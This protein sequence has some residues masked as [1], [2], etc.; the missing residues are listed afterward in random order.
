[1]NECE[2][3]WLSE[4]NMKKTTFPLFLFLA[5]VFPACNEAPQTTE[6]NQKLIHELNERSIARGNK[7]IA[8]VGATLV[9]G[10]GGNPVENATVIIENNTIHFAGKTGDQEIPDGAD[11]ID[12]EGQ[13]I[14]PGFIDAHYHNDYSKLMAPL[15]LHNGVTSVR[16]P[17]AWVDI[18]DSVRMTGKPIPR[19]FLTGPH[20]D[21]YPPAYPDNSYLVKDPEEGRLAV[22][23]FARQGATAIKVYFRLPVTIIREICNAAHEQGLPV[24]GHLEIAN[25]RDAINAG[26]DGI[27]H[28]TS[29][30]TCLLPLREVEKYKQA[31]T[32]D[33]NAR[34][35]GRY[36]A[37]NSIQME[38]N[39]AVDSLIAFLADKGTYVCPTLAVFERQPDRGDSV[40]VNG[41]Q[42]ML[43]FTGLG[44]KAGVRIVVGSHTWVPYAENGFAYFRE[45]ELL[46]DAGMTPMQIIQAATI[47]NARF[48]RIDERLGTIEKGKLADLVLIEG[49][50]LTDIRDM[51]NIKRVMLNGVWVRQ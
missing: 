24:T 25:A 38:N 22:E 44:S 8:L 16:D 21:M 3:A 2:P 37:W 4:I 29:F 32:A 12:V 9:D 34:N 15:F 6:R 13:T 50:P 30:G 7:V 5:G 40:T 43:K 45:M 48:L 20:I 33:N 46:Q 47:E 41:F 18:Y 39:S 23:L 35:Q 14:V 26:L 27:E 31:V 19:L 36:N 17:G 51:R 42:N 11:V 1:L 49:N 10:R 28:I